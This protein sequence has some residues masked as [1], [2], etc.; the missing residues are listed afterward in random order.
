MQQVLQHD[1]VTMAG[2]FWWYGW[3][4]PSGLPRSA[5]VAAWPRQVRGWLTG[6]TIDGAT[7]WA[8]LV[9][10]E[11]ATDA[12]RLVASCYTTHA[13]MLIERWAP[14]PR[15]AYHTM[16][17]RFALPPTLLREMSGDLPPERPSKRALRRARGKGRK[18]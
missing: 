2:Q 4:V 6:Q 14:D 11:D 7:L 10:A 18:G 15:G 12:R 3:A 13:H 17:G 9:W 1:G 5:M 8:G 16:S